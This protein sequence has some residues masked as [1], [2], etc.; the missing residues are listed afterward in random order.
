MLQ[1]ALTW[2]FQPLFIFLTILAYILCSAIL[3][4]ASANADFCSGGEENSPDSTVEDILF[5]LGW[6]DQDLVYLILSFYIGQCSSDTPFA[7]LDEYRD[8]IDNVTL[9][10]LDFTS[11]VAAAG[12]AALS[13]ACSSEVTFIE[14]LNAVL[15]QNLAKLVQSVEDMVE[16]LQ[17]KN[18]VSLYTLPVYS[19]TCTYSITGVTWAWASF[20]VVGGM[21][22][23]M[24]MLR[25]SWKIDVEEDSY[26]QGKSVTSGEFVPDQAPEEQESVEEGYTPY[27]PDKDGDNP[28][29]EEATNEKEIDM[30]DPREEMPA[31]DGYSANVSANDMHTENDKPNVPAEY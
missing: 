26:A 10:V 8:E 11:G 23:A 18:I 22:L 14:A 12:T 29:E 3:I 25:S 2:F 30:S 31:D 27:D 5:N 20:A 6:R 21:G 7:F 28:F 15:I 1:C 4:A 16:I 9:R 24:I 19:G 17:C 13:D